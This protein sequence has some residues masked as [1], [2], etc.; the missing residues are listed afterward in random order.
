MPDSKYSTHK[1]HYNNKWY[2]WR[3]QC[4]F[5][6]GNYR[7]SN[8]VFDPKQANLGPNTITL[9]YVDPNNCKDNASRIINVYETP[10]ADFIV[11]KAVICQDS[12][13]VVEYNGSITSG[14]SYNWTFGNDVMTPGNGTGPF[15][16]KVDQSGN[17]TINLTATKNGCVSQP[18]QLDVEVDPRVPPVSIECIDQ[19]ATEITVGWNSI[20]NIN[21]YTLLIN[22]TP[23]TTTT[24]LT[25]NLTGLTPND[26]VFFELRANSNNVCP[27]TKDTITCIAELCPPIIID[28]SVG[29]TTICL[30]AD[31]KPFQ[32]DALISSGLGTGTGVKTWSG[33]GIN[34][35]GLYDPVAAGPSTGQGHKITLTFVE[36]TCDESASLFVK[37]LAQPK[38]TFTAQDTICV[39]DNLDI[40]YSGT[41]GQPL[42]WKTPPG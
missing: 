10:T 6:P 13:V 3:H 15:N 17:K 7:S 14:G 41:P 1:P 24:N 32:V 5:R 38:S 23:V 12:F 36:G 9:Q 39:F 27:S 8:G 29:D 33:R 4:L 11:D 16:I 20:A 26:V 37:F 30:D 18:Y 2:Y 28:F 31:A 35:D 21:D 34:A 40:T 22:G 42:D 19:K 25:Y